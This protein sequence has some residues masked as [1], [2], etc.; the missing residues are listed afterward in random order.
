LYLL[1]QF[2][3]VC[4]WL[5]S[6]FWLTIAIS[7]MLCYYTRDFFSCLCW[8]SFMYLTWNQ[9]CLIPNMFTMYYSWHVL[10]P[11]HLSLYVDLWNA[12]KISIS[13]SISIHTLINQML[14]QSFR[15]SPRPVT[16]LPQWRV[17][18]IS[19]VFT[20]HI[21]GTKWIKFTKM[22][23]MLKDQIL[24]YWWLVEHGVPCR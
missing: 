14:Q 24:S 22:L 3:A 9:F 19:T 1:L 18:F 15:I 12:N 16:V 13:I 17:Y 5:V 8:T 20:K 11:T 10:C 2:L 23:K 21:C 7:F 6:L 4:I